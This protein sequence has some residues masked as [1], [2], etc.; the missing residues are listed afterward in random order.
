MQLSAKRILAEHR[1][2]RQAFEW[3][4]G[5]IESRFNFAHS[6]SGECVGTVAA[7][8]LGGCVGVTWAC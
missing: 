7:Q 3:L 2:D 1:L 5:E 6:H 8:S 4:V